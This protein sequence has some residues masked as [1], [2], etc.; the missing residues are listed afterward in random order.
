MLK[1]FIKLALM[2]FFGIGFSVT[3]M[4]QSNNDQ[5]KPPPKNEKKDPP[6]IKVPPK[7]DRPKNDKGKPKP[8]EGEYVIEAFV[9]KEDL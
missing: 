4:G 5:K 1:Q 8:P 6:K 2:I 9:R 7:N 3:V